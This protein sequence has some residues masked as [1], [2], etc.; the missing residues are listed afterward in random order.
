MTWR[1][2]GDGHADELLSAHLDGELEPDAERWVVD[3]LGTCADCS[4]SASDL[5]ELRNLLRGLPTVSGAP[6]VEGILSRHRTLIRAGATFVGATSLILGVLALTGAVSRPRL[7]PDVEALRG[8][9]V[10]SDPDH[11]GLEPVQDLGRTYA[12]PADLVHDDVV[13]QRSAVF[14]GTDVAA[15]RYRTTGDSAGGEVSVFEQSGSLD[16]SALPAGSVEHVADRRV[17]FA[18]TTPEVA[19]TELGHLVVTIV[20][21]HRFAV[22]AVVGSMPEHRRGSTWDRF[23]DVCQRYVEVFALGG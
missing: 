1:P 11:G 19:V 20:S 16:W 18:G 21:E 2:P 5:G 3:H 4:A 8:A 6:L 13:L 12:A 10:R 15:V 22:E 7:V 23:H 9:H 17:W 14:D